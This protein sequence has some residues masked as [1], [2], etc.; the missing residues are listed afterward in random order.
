VPVG[1]WW[2]IS[3]A[4][5]AGELARVRLREDVSA[6]AREAIAMVIGALAGSYDVV[7]T[8][9]ERRKVSR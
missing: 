6:T 5:V 7:I 4:G 1:A 2:T 9:V 3:V 8:Y